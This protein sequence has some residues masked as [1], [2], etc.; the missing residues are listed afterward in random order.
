MVGSEVLISSINL[1]IDRE[2]MRVVGGS[3]P[4]QCERFGRGLPPAL[5]I[6]WVLKKKLDLGKSTTGQFA[7]IYI[8]I[9]MWV[10]FNLGFNR[11]TTGMRSIKKASRPN[12]ARAD[13][14]VHPTPVLARP[15]V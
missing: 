3:R 9:Y 10:Y 14:R 2:R 6:D 7:N 13:I 8:Y 11:L 1:P 12:L 5:F 4:E 15:G